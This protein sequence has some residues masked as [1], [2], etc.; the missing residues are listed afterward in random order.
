MTINNGYNLSI[1][2]ENEQTDFDQNNYSL[3]LHDSIHSIYNNAEIIFDDITGFLRET[4]LTNQGVKYDIAMTSEVHNDV[5]PSCE[6]SVEADECVE[7]LQNGVMSNKIKIKLVNYFFEKQ[8]VENRAYQGT[9]SS[10]I[11]KVLKNDFLKKDI[12]ECGSNSIWYQI[13]CDQKTFLESTLLKN[14]YS[15]ATDGFPF[16]MFITFDG[17]FNFKN[18]KT[19][20]DKKPVA[21]LLFNPQSKDTFNENSIID[22]KPFKTGSLKLKKYYLR[23]NVYR[24][25]K[26][27]QYVKAKVSIKD[28][29]IKHLKL[30]IIG[31]NDNVTKYTYYNLS[32]KTV[33]EQ[34]ALKGRII[35]ENKMEFF[36]DRLMIIVPF[37]PL[38]KSGE[39]VDLDL[40]LTYQNNSTEP[41]LYQSGLYL[42]EDC[43]H[44]WDNKS[45]TATTTLIV[46][47]K[48]CAIPNFKLSARLI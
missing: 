28:N 7:N 17:V 9:I 48:S 41:A 12:Q 8:I 30:P 32:Q 2:I 26:T 33:G 40:A 31:T 18:L 10:I 6:Y 47:R 25:Y 11:N 27:G 20:F 45:K 22:C 15:K 44:Y 34:E 13:A 4:L 37:S 36:I 5:S 35:Q 39:T 24:N 23:N 29:I 16:F 43:V 21:K 3:M 38:L 14:S 46:F 42:I 19:M 1:K